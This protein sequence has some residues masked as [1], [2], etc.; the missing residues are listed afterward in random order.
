MFFGVCRLSL[1]D[2]IVQNHPNLTKIILPP[3]SLEESTDQ[4]S[5]VHA[6]LLLVFFWFFL[7]EHLTYRFFDFLIFL[8]R[9]LKQEV[10]LMT[11]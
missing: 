1:W 4:K 3:A 10:S 11:I 6:V 9:D 2:P 5:I 7:N 8:M